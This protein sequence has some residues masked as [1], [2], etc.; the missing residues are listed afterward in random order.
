[1]A[2]FSKLNYALGDEDTLPEYQL[3]PQDAGHVVAVAGSG[4]RIVPLVAKRPRAITCVDILQ[5]QLDLTELRVESIR[6]LSFG[7]FMALFGYPEYPI[8]VDKRKALFESLTLR[9]QTGQRLAEFFSKSEWQAIIYLGE[10]ERMLMT[11]SKL[12]RFVV[13]DKLD[14]LF[15]F[16]NLEDQR[17][18]VKSTAFPRKRWTLALALFGNATALNALLY[19]GDFPKKNRMGS[20]FS[21]YRNMFE[22]LF[23][24][25]LCRDSYFFQMLVLGRLVNARSA[26]M[27]ADENLYQTIKENLAY[28]Q[29]HYIQTDIVSAINKIEEPVDFVSISDVPSFMSDGPANTFLVDIAAN[30]APNATVVSRGHLRVVRPDSK[31]FND[32]SAQAGEVF[33]SERTGLWQIQCYEKQ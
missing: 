18:F 32:I 20:T 23:G 14:I 4:G 15:E 26:M 27:E 21:I 5:E 3:L 9:Q 25:I 24:Q 22:T 16:D 17:N 6:Q 31:G 29:I 7:D 28:T 13:G 33:S 1:M 19:R 2:Y 12:I 10:F 11:V 8:T 30:L